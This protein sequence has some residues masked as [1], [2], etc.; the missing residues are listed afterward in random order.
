[1][2]V[3]LFSVLLLVPSSISIE[4]SPFYHPLD[5]TTPNN[6]TVDL[7]RL[8]KRQNNCPSGYDP[9][10]ALGNSAVCCRDGTRCTRDAANNI[11]CCPTGA[12]CTGTLTGTTGTEAPSTGFMF[13]QPTSAT[14]TGTST[15]DGAVITGS[16]VPG[17]PYPFVYIPTTFANAETCSSYYSQ[18]ESQCSRCTASLGGVNG[19]TVAGPGGAGITVQGST[20]TVDAQSVCSSLSRKACYGLQVAYC[21][22]FGTSGATGNQFIN[23][24]QAAP[25]RS[26][27]LR[28]LAVGL[29]VGIAGLFV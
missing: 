23:P 24:G 11:A 4:L 7:L 14:T 29:A 26:S 13:P 25:R 19:V 18:C 6:Q 5:N 20:P 1:M 21:T 8:L 28:D 16:T 27:S 17:A 22:A 3:S 2:R 9:C 12:S 15:S 10:S